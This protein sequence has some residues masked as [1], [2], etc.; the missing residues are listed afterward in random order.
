MS[1]RSKSIDVEIRETALHKGECVDLEV[2]V[3][4]KVIGTIHQET[5]K[6]S[7]LVRI[8]DK[9]RRVASVEEAIET[10]ISEYNLHHL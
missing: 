8:D 5:P 2:V 10:I 6:E 7:V 1:K 9:K 3:S 4:H